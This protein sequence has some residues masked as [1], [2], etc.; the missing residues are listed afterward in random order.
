MNTPPQKI[1]CENLLLLRKKRITPP[2]VIYHLDNVSLLP[3]HVEVLK[4]TRLYDFD[5]QMII[6]SFFMT[7]SLEYFYSKISQQIADEEI[8]QR[9]IKNMNYKFISNL[10]NL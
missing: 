8:A 9:H 5:I 3:M 4:F 10:I 7:N 2:F 1:E 6:G